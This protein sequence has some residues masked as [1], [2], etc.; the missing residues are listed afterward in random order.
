MTLYPKTYSL[1][2]NQYASIAETLRVSKNNNNSSTNV[3]FILE[4][5]R[6]FWRYRNKNT[7]NKVNDVPV[8]Q[9][10]DFKSLARIKPTGELTDENEYTF[11]LQWRNIYNN[12]HKTIEG[13][14]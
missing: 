4:T 7:T 3:V 11:K 12:F 2:S 8:A 14:L 9:T 6:Y 13:Q 10:D 5:P 1:L